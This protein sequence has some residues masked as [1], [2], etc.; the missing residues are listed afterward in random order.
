MDIHI[1]RIQD[2][3]SYL[4]E[5]LLID[6]VNTIYQSDD[7]KYKTKELMYYFESGIWLEDYQSDENNLI[8]THIKRGILSQDTL[9][10]FLEN[11]DKEQL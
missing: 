1:K 11:I 2:M 7:L 5:L 8:P 4:D 10:N 6:D 3:E 9:Y